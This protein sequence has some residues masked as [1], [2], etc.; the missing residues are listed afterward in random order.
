MLMRW[1]MV[2]VCLR[3]LD[4]LG[5]DAARGGGMQER[6]ARAADAGARGLVDEP[7]AALAQC[8]QRRID[9]VDLVALD[10]LVRQE[11]AGDLVEQLAVRRDDLPRRAM[12][13]E[14]QLALLLVADAT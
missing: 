6:H 11:L 8:R 2:S 9:V 13:L 10:R 3:G 14:G 12:R 7:E 4:D 1:A 5:E